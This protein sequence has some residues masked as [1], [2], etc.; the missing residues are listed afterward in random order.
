MGRKF[1]GLLLQAE[2]A[3]HAESAQRNNRQ[4]RCS[5]TAENFLTVVCVPLAMVLQTAQGP[6]AFKC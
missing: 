4:G 2:R 1:A 3:D 5:Q 6:T